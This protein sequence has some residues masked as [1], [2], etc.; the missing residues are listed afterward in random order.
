MAM[1][2]FISAGAACRIGVNRAR[3]KRKNREKP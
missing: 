1:R 3:K 2:A